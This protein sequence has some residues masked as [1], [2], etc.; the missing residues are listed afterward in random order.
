MSWN[1]FCYLPIEAIAAAID[2]KMKAMISDPSY[3]ESHIK[4]V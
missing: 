4:S 2:P 3:I 1:L